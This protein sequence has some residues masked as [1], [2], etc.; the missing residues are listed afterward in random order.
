M[1]RFCLSHQ[2]SLRSISYLI[3]NSHFGNPVLEL[4]QLLKKRL[5]HPQST[6]EEKFPYFSLHARRGP[7]R[8][9]HLFFCAFVPDPELLASL[10]KPSNWLMGRR[11]DGKGPWWGWWWILGEGDEGRVF[12]CDV[13]KMGKAAEIGKVSR[14]AAINKQKD[15]RE[16]N[17]NGW[18]FLQKTLG[19]PISLEKSPG[20]G[21]VLIY[22][23]KFHSRAHI[24]ITRYGNP[25]FYF[26]Y[27][28][29]KIAIQWTRLLTEF[30][31]RLDSHD[32]DPSLRPL[33]YTYNYSLILS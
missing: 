22:I 17:D 23:R 18:N 5:R 20:E 9:R 3:T 33:G 26:K 1:A 29:K 19:L 7:P 28:I 8:V 14:S 31:R 32:R 2:M 27:L 6:K 11:H 30:A 4:T 12:G 13:E 15:H 24:Q 21:V 16:T 10:F 25:P